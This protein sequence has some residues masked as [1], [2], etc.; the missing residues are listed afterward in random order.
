LV[1][2]RKGSF[3]EETEV[4]EW[5]V[6]SGSLFDKLFRKST[7]I[8]ATLGPASQDE[9]TIASM[10]KMGVNVVRLNL[11]HGNQELHLRCIEM[12][13]RIERSLGVY[14]GILLD[15]QGPKIR[16]GRLKEEPV[17]L[18]EGEI[19]DLTPEEVE[20]D[21][22]VLSINYRG[23]PGEVKKGDRILLDD[24]NIELRVV[25][26]RDKRVRCLI[27]NGGIISSHRGV[28]LPDTTLRTAGITPK[29]KL[30]L[31]F[32]LDNGVDFV[33]LS[34]VRSADDVKKLRKLM[35]DHG[36]VIPIIA[37]IEKREALKDIDGILNVSDGIMVARGDLGAETSPQEVPILQKMIIQK[38]NAAGKPVITATQMLESMIHKPRPTRAEAA[39]V[40][41]AIIDGS[42]CV[43]LSGE[44]AVGDYPVEAVKVMSE[45]A[46]RTEKAMYSEPALTHIT[47][48]PCAPLAGDIASSLSNSAKGVADL[49][50]PE[51]IVA[52]T[53]TGRTATLVSNARPS[54]PVIAM[55][56]D[57]DVLR[58]LS[59]YWGVHGVYIERVSTSEELFNRAEQILISRGICREEDIVVI[60]GGIP[61]LAG[62][63]TNMIKVH[64]LRLGEKNI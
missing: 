50:R 16:T 31:L 29:D 57:E 25:G 22:R 63:P 6:K 48:T 20:G 18:K 12:F 36:K 30:D 1:K 41:N 46:L 13:R 60:I 28:N 17:E 44:T 19:I 27:M 7:K 32:G 23:L 9:E 52:F 8:I 26:L 33:A 24:G 49:L 14:A 15:L 42:D 10:L 11:S 43:M 38:C 45:I 56:P 2:S 21:E 62:T 61:V 5:K 58:R 53:L 35:K 64:R 37:K 51:Y 59:I 4:G 55:S 54:V 39:D 34:F 40:A 47:R 3:P